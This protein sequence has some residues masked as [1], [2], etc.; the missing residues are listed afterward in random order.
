M[1]V[2]VCV[3][4]CLS[5]CGCYHNNMYNNSMYRSVCV[6]AVCACVCWCASM[7]VHT[8]IIYNKTGKSCGMCGIEIVRQMELLDCTLFGRHIPSR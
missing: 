3:C 2:C 8:T 7:K 1:C 6:H 5:V 4:V